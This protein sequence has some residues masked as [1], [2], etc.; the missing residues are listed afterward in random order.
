MHWTVRLEETTSAGEVKT[1]ELVTISRP[2]VVSTLAEVGLMLDESKALLAK[3]QASMLCGQVAAYAAHHRA[4]AA[5]GALQSLKERRT[6]RLQTLFG[7]VEAEAPRFKLC[8]CRQSAP[9]A[10]VT[11]ALVCALLAASCTPEAERVQAELGAH[12]VQGW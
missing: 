6:R 3:L 12:F 11:V 10:E 7:T 8:R 4:C 2:G 5:C 9:M 1:I